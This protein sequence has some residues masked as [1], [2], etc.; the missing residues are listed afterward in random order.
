VRATLGR[1]GRAL[2]EGGGGRDAGQA[3]NDS[4]DSELTTGTPSAPTDSLTAGLA[5]RFSW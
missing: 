1:R 3:M 5:A 4:H 2:E